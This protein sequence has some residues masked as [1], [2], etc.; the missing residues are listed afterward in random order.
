MF[1]RAFS[2][3]L[4]ALTT[5]VA[6][7]SD[8]TDTS[9]SA[10]NAQV[11]LDLHS[12]MRSQSN[13]LL[14]MAQKLDVSSKQ[15]FTSP[16]KLS[17][18]LNDAVM[19]MDQIH[20]NLPSLLAAQDVE[21]ADLRQQVREGV[22][23]KSVLETRTQAIDVYRKGLLG[24]LDAS[25]ARAKSTFNALAATNRHD[26]SNQTDQASGLSRDLQAARTMIYMQL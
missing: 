5:L 6:G 19:Q 18:S 16:R 2:I 20:M 1:L 4:V 17:R 3:S 15:G 7:C 10:R 24:S 9:F 23:A 26:L 21:I 22:M 25:A 8:V 14:S 11:E 12:L 13:E